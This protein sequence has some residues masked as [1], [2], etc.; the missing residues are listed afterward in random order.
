MSLLVKNWK[1]HTPQ[2]QTNLQHAI[3]FTYYTATFIHLLEK[4][5]MKVFKIY[6]ASCVAILW[7][8]EINTMKL[9]NCNVSKKLKG[10]EDFC[11]AL[12]ACILPIKRQLNLCLPLLPTAQ[13]KCNCAS[14]K[15]NCHQC[16]SHYNSA[17][18]KDSQLSAML[19]NIQKTFQVL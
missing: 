5:I 19:Q 10:C 17:F 14:L 15:I 16:F 13:I 12:L 7:N 1:R 3:S 8:T 6:T 2:N 11:K 4:Q 18:S 9:I